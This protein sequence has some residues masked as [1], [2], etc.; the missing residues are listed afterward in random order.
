MFIDK[1]IEMFLRI[2]YQISETFVHSER[3]MFHFIQDCGEYHDTLYMF[4]FQEV[5]LK[6]IT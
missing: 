4:I 3:L 5:N 1:D 6:F 2:R